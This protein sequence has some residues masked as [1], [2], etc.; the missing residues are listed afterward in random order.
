MRKGILLL[1][2]FSALSCGTAKEL[3][4]TPNLQPKCRIEG[5]GSYTLVLDAGMGGWSLFWQPVVQELKKTMRV[6]V[7]DRPGYA[8][9]AVSTSPRDAKT[10]AQEIHQLLQQQ[11]ITTNIILA[12]HSMGGLHVRMYQHL[13]SQEVKGLIL[14]DAAHPQQF[15][16]LPQR[17]SEI[18]DEQPKSLE[19][20]IQL[21]K[22]DRL[23]YA[24]GKIPTLGMPEYLLNDYYAV[25][26]TPEY[27]Q[28]MKMEVVSFEK[29]L[30][31][32]DSL[33]KNLGNLPL[34]VIASE[35]SMNEKVL[36]G[37]KKGYPFTEHNRIWFELQQEHAQL[38]T[39]TSFVKSSKDHYLLLSDSALVIKSVQEYYVN[40]F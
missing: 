17:F 18:A 4:Q 27:Y 40:H 9:N 11:G 26:T 23:K 5:S 25:T 12:G 31:Q 6:C 8:M 33:S 13:Y 22:K 39:N 16:K 24:K 35:N 37:T 7:I 21:A 19:K 14:I 10:V 34:L 2:L 28:T 20:V 29:S 38:S 32:V 30:A 36:P 1:L 3:I 15:Q